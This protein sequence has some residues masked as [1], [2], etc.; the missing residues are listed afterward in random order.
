MVDRISFAHI[1]ASRKALSERASVPSLILYTFFLAYTIHP[2]STRLS[3]NE[4]EHTYSEHLN[5]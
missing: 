2:T 5:T 1:A 3:N 4:L